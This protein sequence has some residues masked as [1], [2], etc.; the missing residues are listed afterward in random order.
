M[1]LPRQYPRAERDLEWL[2]EKPQSAYM[3]VPAVED[4]WGYGVDTVAKV[5]V[6]D[7]FGV[8]DLGTVALVKPNNVEQYVAGTRLFQ[9]R[10]VAEAAAA[11]NNA[12]RRV[13]AAKA[14]VVKMVTD[15]EYPELL[16]LRE[17]IAG[18]F[19]GGFDREE[20][21]GLRAFREVHAD[22]P[23]HATAKLGGEGSLRGWGRM[24]D[25]EVYPLTPPEP[26]R[27]ERDPLDRSLWRVVQV[28]PE[29]FIRVNGGPCPVPVDVLV[30]VL[31]ADFSPSDKPERGA[32]GEFRWYRTGKPSD[33]IAYRVV[34][35]MRVPPLSSVVTVD[36]TG[37]QSQ[38]VAGAFAR[39]MLNKDL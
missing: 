16:E 19:A 22:W 18:H 5:P 15:A 11:H 36:V 4:D 2:Y 3:V 23:E 10:D 14:T 39:Q 8:A 13:R 37:T 34:E 27:P 9:Q 38:D 25:G 28:I 7:V 21:E 35:P 32:A 1:E 31:R 12:Q 24:I 29:G 20:L 33:I 30:E 26:G 17:A 6:L